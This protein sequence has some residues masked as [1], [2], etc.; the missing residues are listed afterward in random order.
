MVQVDI[1]WSYGLGAGFAVSAARQLG[2]MKDARET[3]PGGDA[4][5]S[6]PFVNRYFIAA[7]VYAA[8]F[9]APS[10]VYLLWQFPSWETMHVWDRSLSALLVTAFAITN[11]TQSVLA[12]WLCSR[13]IRAGNSFR[14]YLHFVIAYFCMFFIL[15]HGW[16]GRGYQRFFSV[17]RAD[18]LAWSTSNVGA[19]FKS[20]VAIT[21]CAM[22][23]VLLPVMF[24][25]MV[26]WLRAGYEAAGGSV[27]E[28]GARIGWARPILLI[29]ATV[30]VCGLGSAIVASLLIHWLGWVAGAAVFIVVAFL[31][32][33][34]K[35]GLF[36]I[37]YRALTLDEA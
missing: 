13:C 16:D 9:F 15:V 23:V 28:R 18:F 35:K 17:T 5:A 26:K 24:Y 34:R 6:A 32:L 31:L 27:R 11:V 19:W 4:E 33:I 25:Y 1:F 8:C 10:G 22:G 12:F 21:L 7:L 14:A 20:D 3:A 37:V 30:F 36:H 29:L 2:K